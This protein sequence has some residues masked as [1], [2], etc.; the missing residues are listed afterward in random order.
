MCLDQVCKITCKVAASW[1]RQAWR[2]KQRKC[3][4]NTIMESMYVC[5]YKDLAMAIRWTT[6][7]FLKKLIN[8][9]WCAHFSDAILA[10][11][12]A[13]RLLFSSISLRLLFESVYF[14]YL[15]FIMHNF[16][17][18]YHVFLP[19]FRIEIHLDKAKSYR[20]TAP[21]AAHHC[22]YNSISVW[23][24]LTMLKSVRSKI[25]IATIWVSL[26]E[27]FSNDSLCNSISILIISCD[28]RYF[29]LL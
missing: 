27:I 28:A 9:L 13:S 21:T 7:C 22:V 11:F 4:Y 15:E 12:F 10:P 17:R 1:L 23:T 14:V 29:C 2:D 24:T 8:F 26:L 20:I 6:K 5:V 18:K 19:I 16:M 3:N 25:K